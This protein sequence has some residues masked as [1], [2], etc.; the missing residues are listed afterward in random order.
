MSE[1]ATQKVYMF[2]ESGQEYTSSLISDLTGVSRST[3]NKALRALYN[4][5]AIERIKRPGV[6]GFVY[7][8]RQESLL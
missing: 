6:R 3:A 4:S 2:M 7:L 1:A 5:S 8:S